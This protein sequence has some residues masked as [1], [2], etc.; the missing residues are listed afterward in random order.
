MKSL[1]DLQRVN[2]FFLFA[3]KR[4]QRFDESRFQGREMKWS[5]S[6]SKDRNLSF[7]FGCISTSFWRCHLKS[8]RRKAL[9]WISYFTPS[10]S[11]VPPNAFSNISEKNKGKNDLAINSLNLLK[12]PKLIRFFGPFC[13]KNA[14]LRGISRDP[15]LTCIDAYTDQRPE[16]VLNG[17]YY[18]KERHREK[19]QKDFVRE[20]ISPQRKHQLY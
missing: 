12:G 16:N 1:R 15:C 7:Q 2:D 11:S 3:E 13:L 19:M 6:S 4:I 9:G 10:T 18:L 14:K 8:I 17:L 5:A 20:I